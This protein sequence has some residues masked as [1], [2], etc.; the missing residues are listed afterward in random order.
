MDGIVVGSRDEVAIVP[1]GVFVCAD[2]EFQ[3]ELFNHKI[4]KGFQFIMG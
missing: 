4:V 3:G 2:N 1:I